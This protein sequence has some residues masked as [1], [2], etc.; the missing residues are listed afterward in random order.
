MFKLKSWEIE[1]DII[2]EMV[3]LKAISRVQYF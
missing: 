1:K 2:T 3:F